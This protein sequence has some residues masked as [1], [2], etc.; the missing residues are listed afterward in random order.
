[1]LSFTRNSAGTRMAGASPRVRGSVSTP[2]SAAAAHVSV[3]ARYT[4]ASSVPDRPLK[5]RLNERTETAP[6]AGDWPMPMHGP[7][8]GSITRAPAAIRSARAPLRATM[9]STCLE[10]GLMTRDTPGAMVLP[11]SMAA[12]VS[13]SRTDEFVQDPMQTCC[14]G[15][16]AISS[17]GTT[18]SGLCGTAANGTSAPR[19]ISTVSS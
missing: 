12:T 19:S 13:K 16:P 9:V 7:Q 15:C 1:M 14:T 11:R 2:V 17:T 6:L 18:A 10:P 5:F 8:P 3:P 4:R